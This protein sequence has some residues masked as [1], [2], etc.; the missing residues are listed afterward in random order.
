MGK[1]RLLATL[2]APHKANNSE[3]NVKEQAIKEFSE[4]K[5]ALSKE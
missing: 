1:S 5:D 3:R 4:K 2:A